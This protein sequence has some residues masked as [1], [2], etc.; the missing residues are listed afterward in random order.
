MLKIAVFGFFGP[1]Q[2][3]ITPA[4]TNN[5]PSPVTTDDFMRIVW[6]L[7]P[8]ETRIGNKSSSAPC[9]VKLTQIASNPI[10]VQSISN[11]LAPGAAFLNAD[12]YVAIIDAVKILAPKTIQSTLR[13]LADLHP[14]TNIIIAADRQNEPDAL[15]SDEIREVLGLHPDLPVYPYVPDAPK[16]VFRLIRRLARYIDDPERIAPPIFADMEPAAP[17]VNNTD[18]EAPAEPSAPPQAHIHGLD[19][20]AITVADLDRS[21]DFYRG[22][23]GFRVL[24]H[25]DFPGDERGFTITYLDAGCGVLELFSFTHGETQPSGWQ[26]DDHH[27]GIRHVAL[28][29]TGLD[30]IAEQLACA[31]VSFTIE[32]MDAVGGVR[33][34]FFTDPDGTLLELI[35]GDLIYSRR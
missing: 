8:P 14:N 28:R 34:A 12:G 25:L 17:P 33:I 19:H 4:A 11:Q 13:R 23:L 26:P 20:V 29:V 2:N 6:E 5:H 21:L 30:A 3:R 24:G 22:L 18:P 10:Y 31:G 15:S 35:E 9:F 7:E 16:T 32:P 27:V 1:D